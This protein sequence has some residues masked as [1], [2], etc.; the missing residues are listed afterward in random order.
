MEDVVSCYNYSMTF[1]TESRF[2]GFL[3]L[4]TAFVVSALVWGLFYYSAQSASSRNALSV[5]GSAKIRVSADQAK[6]TLVISRT[7]LT[8]GLAGGYSA[9]A[10]DLSSVRSLLVAENIPDGAVVESPVSMNQLYD[11]NG[12]SDTRYELRQTLTV[13]SDDVALLTALSKKIPSLASGGAIVSIQSLEYYYSKLPDLRVSL[14]SEAIQDAKARAQ[15]IAEGTGRSIGSIQSAS[16]GV[17]QVL[18]PNSV[19][20]SDYGAYDTSSIEK[21]IMVSVKAVFGL[22]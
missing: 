1:N 20:I 16:G 7:V 13:Q 4:G 22:R 14:L 9:V 3:V 18:A 6:L 21:D 10:R 15:K 8:S 19:E 11:P 5:T 2:A 17:V 12:G